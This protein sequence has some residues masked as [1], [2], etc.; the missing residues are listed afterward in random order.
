MVGLDA[1][2][3]DLRSVER[4]ESILREVGQFMNCPYMLYMTLSTTQPKTDCSD[5]RDQLLFPGRDHS[6]GENH[7]EG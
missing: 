5:A 7:P 2:G 1:G 6:T 3:D 4:S